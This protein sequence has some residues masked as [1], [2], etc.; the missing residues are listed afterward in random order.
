MHVHIYIDDVEYSDYVI[1][2]SSEQKICTGIGN[3]D[4]L[5]TP[6][7]PVE[8]I[9]WTH[10]VIEENGN[11]KVGSYYI[12][13]VSKRQPSGEWEVSAQDMSKRLTDYFIAEQYTVEGQSYSTP[14]IR[15]FLNEA[16]VDFSIEGSGDQ[17]L[18]NYTQLGLVS[19]YDQIVTLLQM[20]GWYMYFDEND[21]CHIGKLGL[22]H[23]H[24]SATLNDD[25]II[26]IDVLED[27]KM[28]RNRVLVT[29]GSD[30]YGSGIVHAEIIEHTR[31]NYDN[32]DIRTAVISNSAIPT[33]TDAYNM[34]SIAIK[35]FDHITVSKTIQAK[36]S[37]GLHVGVTVRVNTDLFTGKGLVTTYGTS[38][39]KDGLVTNLILDERCPRLFGFF[40]PTDNVYVATFGDGVYG[41]MLRTDPNWYPL[42]YGLNDLR[43]TDLHITNGIFSCVTAA[44]EAYYANN[45]P[46]II[47]G[48]YGVSGVVAESLWWNLL[49]LP[50][51][52]T[53]F[54]GYTDYTHTY[55]GLKARATIQDRLYNTI[56]IA[57]DTRPVENLG[58]Y[59][60]STSYANLP[61]ILSGVIYNP[62]QPTNISGTIPTSGFESVI[63]EYTAGGAFKDAYQ[64]RLST[65][66]AS[67]MGLTITDDVIASGYTKGIGIYDIETDGTTDYVSIGVNTSGLIIPW[68]GNYGYVEDMRWRGIRPYSRQLKNMISTLNYQADFVNTGSIYVGSVYQNFDSNNFWELAV[69]E[70][71]G[72]GQR[73]IF[74]TDS[75]PPT[76]KV[77]YK[78][79]RLNKSVGGI[80]PTEDFSPYLTVTQDLRD[81]VVRRISDS[82]YCVYGWDEKTVGLYSGLAIYK[83]EIDFANNTI[84]R[85]ELYS[86]TSDILTVDNKPP[87]YWTWN[88]WV[89]AVFNEDK[90]HFAIQTFTMFDDGEFRDFW[91]RAEYLC[92][93]FVTETLDTPL[94]TIFEKTMHTGIDWVM[95]P[96]NTVI[97][98]FLFPFRD[99]CQIYF[100][101]YSAR[102]YTGGPTPAYDLNISQFYFIPGE[103]STITTLW[104]PGTTVDSWADVVFGPE[105]GTSDYSGLQWYTSTLVNAEHILASWHVKWGV[106]KI[107]VSNGIDWKIR[108]GRLKEFY[109]SAF[110]VNPCIGLYNDNYY[111]ACSGYS[112]TPPYTSSYWIISSRSWEPVVYDASGPVG[113]N[114]MS[115]FQQRDTNNNQVI[116]LAYKIPASG[117]P[118]EFYLVETPITAPNSMTTKVPIPLV[119]SPDGRWYSYYNT[120][121]SKLGNF[122]IPSI[123]DKFYYYDAGVY[124]P[125]NGTL[126]LTLQRDGE[127]FNILQSGLFPA[128]LEISDFS[129]LVTMER[130]VESTHVYSITTSGLTDLSNIT[131]SGTNG[132]YSGMLYGGG[133]LA[134]DYRYAM[135]K[136]PWDI[137]AATFIFAAYSGGIGLIDVSTL[138]TF[139]GLAQ[140]V[141]G[142]ISKVETSNTFI[143]D[144]FIFTA[145]SGYP[146]IYNMSEQGPVSGEW[147]FKQKDPNSVFIDYSSGYPA[148][149]TTVVRLDD[150]L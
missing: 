3:L 130:P 90:V 28:L 54:S 52:H 56:K 106:D 38:M 116:W 12:S 101:Y 92:Y 70:D 76:G 109:E 60:M 37:L 53:L 83:D 95:A 150:R 6:N 44:G 118:T 68:S 142:S 136:P 86:M 105:L 134:A 133:V 50:N 35:E 94:D 55:S 47:P 87:N 138:S 36:N 149:R 117:I 84:E 57:A 17:L 111:I 26:S 7:L 137:S 9:P 103:V 10:I 43:V 128:R 59:L 139:S 13:S 99:S 110:L 113:Y 127:D 30:L 2:Y 148:A 144:Q 88:W 18:S 143:P 77:R 66:Q 120:E 40:A 115:P 129:P 4:I 49:D 27:D 97:S 21:T 123:A 67:G 64:I 61:F 32:K 122:V 102:W 131:M 29:G 146:N 48:T 14:W 25:D 62:Y 1:S 140:S 15:K 79:T 132:T 63:V 73:D 112:I 141:T 104:E 126:Y 89:E 22:D 96:A 33:Y 23:S 8:L 108:D 82:I 34:A 19:A 81:M 114:L 125:F 74:S 39:S 58:D 124:L 100:M 65:A 75:N 80:T 119:A 78:R 121:F 20:N 42:N 16:G 71:E 45:S 11:T 135:F 72:F 69:F 98:T 41:K 107:I 46:S 24:D 5:F 51:V 145:I 91:L 31:W 147:G 85:T 93:N